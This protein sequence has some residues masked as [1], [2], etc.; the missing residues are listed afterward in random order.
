MGHYK[1]GLRLSVCVDNCGHS[2]GSIF[3][4]DFHQNWNRLKNPKNKKRVRLGQHRTCTN[5]FPILPLQL[6]F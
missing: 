1:T 6:P 4:I 5:P 2:H 3:L